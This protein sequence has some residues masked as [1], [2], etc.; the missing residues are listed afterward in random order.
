MQGI[1]M[2]EATV[3][4]RSTGGGAGLAFLLS[5]HIKTTMAL[6]AKLILSHSK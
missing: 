5:I 2:Q 3:T 6:T 1:S 4:Y